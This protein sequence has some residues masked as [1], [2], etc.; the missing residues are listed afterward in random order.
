MRVLV[1]GGFGYLGGRIAQ[2]L[3]E[4]GHQ[5]ILGSRIDH[6]VPSWLPKAKVLKMGW[7]DGKIMRSYCKNV[8]T[9][10]HVAGINAQECVL[11]PVRAI[12]FNG[13]E[14][15]RL[16]QAS[17]ASGV[18]KFIYLSTVHVYSSSLVGVINENT[19]PTNKHP[20]AT[21]HLVGENAVLYQSDIVD[22]FTG[23]VLR[24]SNTVGAPTNKKTNCWTLAVN[25]FCRQIVEDGKIE[26]QSP[27]GIERDFIPIS[28]LC[29]AINKAIDS[30]V[31]SG[32]MN[33]SASNSMS[34]QEIIDVIKERSILTLGFSPE[35]FFHSKEAV[36]DRQS[37][38]ISNIKAKEIM[39]LEIKIE[40]EIDLLL[41]KCKKW[42]G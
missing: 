4:Q 15:A 29:E 32:V 31:D 10:I 30:D 39:P 38:M 17:I 40:D 35:V 1:T 9:V 12:E 8:D 25:D 26:V 34:L 7:G 19:C 11:D 5:I 28:M 13:L 21:S 36:S 37:L 33:I 3:A 2:G 18:Q 16:V 6:A 27:M 22:D 20:Y 14:T 41:Q 42:F 24:V 23:I